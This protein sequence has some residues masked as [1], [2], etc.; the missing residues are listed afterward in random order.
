MDAAL[1]SDDSLADALPNFIRKLVVDETGLTGRYDFLLP[2]G[3]NNQAILLD[4]MLERYGLILEPAKCKIRMLVIE[5][6]DN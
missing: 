6:Q 1:L 5:P 3:D 4:A 2:Y